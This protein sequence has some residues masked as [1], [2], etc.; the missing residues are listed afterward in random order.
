MVH[1]SNVTIFNATSPINLIS[2]TTTSLL[3]H[4]TTSNFNNVSQVMRTECFVNISKDERFDLI[5]Q[6]HTAKLED[7][8]RRYYG[9]MPLP[10]TIIATSLTILFL[11]STYRAIKQQRVSR[12]CYAL[13]FNRSVGDLI[14]CI[15]N[16]AVIGYCLL[17]PKV[18]RDVVPAIDT[19]FVGS[20]WAG[21]VSYVSLSL[22]KLYAVSKPFSYRNKVTMRKVIYLIML[23]MVKIPYLNALTKC[24]METCLRAMY[25]S[26]N[27]L[28]IIVY[29]F[30][31]FI[32]FG[33]LIYVRKARKFVTSFN[34]KNSNNKQVMNTRFPF[35]K[36]SL[37]VATFAAMNGFY[38]IWAILLQLNT[39][40]CYFQK[41]FNQMITYLGFVR[42]TLIMRVCVDP[43]LTFITD[44]QM[45]R[46]LY[47]VLGINGKINPLSSQ[48]NM[49]K[50]D[51]EEIEDDINSSEYLE[52]GKR[53]ANLTGT[54][55][56]T[57]ES[58]IKAKI[59]NE[60]VTTTATIHEPPQDDVIEVVKE[61]DLP[62]AIKN[63][64]SV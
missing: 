3:D 4:L 63:N 2:T 38:V 22:L 45:R 17:A 58:S 51:G 52:K 28:T 18:N 5:K 29:F 39:D 10:F 6:R 27:F 34:K 21:M 7:I 13:L 43:I 30:T 11:I 49:I 40:Q 47:N 59:D 54:T 15:S 35:W 62:E 33:T 14:C 31:L 61:E 55:V 53:S 24:R 8:F 46:S 44:F 12:K 37:N 1:N 9:W 32:F 20:F 50:K 26:R 19:F 48:K 60:L 16:F 64:K 25:R 41:H 42:L 36:L 23:T 57:N 56:L